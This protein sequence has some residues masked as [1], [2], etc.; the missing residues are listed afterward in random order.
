[1]A[2]STKKSTEIATEIQLEPTLYIVD[3]DD[4]E[5]EYESKRGDKKK[6][7]WLTLLFIVLN[8]A[9]IAFVIV[10]E[11]MSGSAIASFDMALVAIGENIEFFMA[12]QKFNYSPAKICKSL[13]IIPLSIQ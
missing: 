5:R 4:F 13:A 2:K 6:N 3:G 9:A 7:L 12:K 10:S 8:T 1:M 11:Q